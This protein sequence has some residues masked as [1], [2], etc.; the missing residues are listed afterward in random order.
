MDLES[1]NDH[2]GEGETGQ[3]KVW[4]RFIRL[5]H[6]TVVIGFIVAYFTDDK[7]LVL[8]LWAG[9]TVG[10]LVLARI[11]WGF[12]GPRHARFS[13]F[14]C[15]PFKALRYLIALPL[16]RS[17]R[18]LG[19]SPAGG[20]MVAVLLVGLLSASWTGYR[21]YYSDDH[22]GEGGRSAL[23]YILVAPAHAHGTETHGEPAAA[24]EFW[25]QVHGWLA[26]GLLMLAVLHFG[27]VLLASFAHREN[28]VRAMV[29]GRKRR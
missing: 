12:V 2:T 6:W 7:L 13:D 26:D 21:H 9:Y 16:G 19:H 11:V 8:H 3:I 28:L 17:E 27:G 18:H 1:R 15:N 4:D 14:I 10:A 24:P 23:S 5:Y 22:A 20:L 29:T 25:G